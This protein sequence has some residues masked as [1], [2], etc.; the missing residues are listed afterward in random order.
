MTSK[1]T[2]RNQSQRLGFTA[3][4]YNAAVQPVTHYTCPAGK[5]ARIIG[6]CFCEGTG[7]AATA[8][9]DVAGIS[10]AEWQATGGN[11]NSDS[12]QN[13]AEGVRFDFDE[14]FE[15]GET[16]VTDQNSGT[17]AEFHLFARIEERPA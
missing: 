12:P 13:M 17:N 2:V 3:I 8:D 5:I 9:L 11:A 4:H 15:A 6:W 16:L 14:V 7:S 1:L 10:I